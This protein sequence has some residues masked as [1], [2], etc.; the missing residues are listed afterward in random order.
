MHRYLSILKTLR[1]SGHSPG[2]RAIIKP[3]GWPPVA[4][5]FERKYKS[6]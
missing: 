4:N 2:V 3:T 1:L 5:V 6:L